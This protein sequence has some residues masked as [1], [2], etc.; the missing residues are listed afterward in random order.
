MSQRQWAQLR[1]HFST[2][3]RPGYPPEVGAIALLGVSRSL[4]RT[5]YL[6]AELLLPGAGDVRVATHG[7]L[8]LDSRYL[9]RAHLAMRQRKLAGL[10]VFHTHPLADE[11]VGFSA[12]DDDQEPFLVEN[13]KEMAP[14]T[15]FLS[16]VAGRR[17]QCGR[18]WHGPERWTPL[19][20]LKVIGDCLDN[21]S[22]AGDPAPA[23]PPPEAVFDRGLA[24]TGAGALARL[25]DMDVVVVG[26]SGTGSLMCEL[27]ARGGCRRIRVI[28]DQAVEDVNLNRILHAG[29]R[30]VRT[31]TRKVDLIRDSLRAYELDCEVEAIDGN[32]LDATFLSQIKTADVIVGCVDAAFPRSLLCDLA[33]QYLIPYIDVG[34][35]I[36]GDPKGLVALMARTSYV[37]PGR[38]CLSCTGIVEPR[39]L[40]FESLTYEERQRV[41]RLGYSDDLLITQPAVM[42]LNMRAAS[43]G[44]MLLRHLLQPFLLEPVPVT[45]S[46]NVLTYT[47]VA[48]GAPRTPNARCLTCRENP[49]L[50]CGDCG[51][52]IG[53][54]P[55]AVAAIT[56]RSLSPIGVQTN[57]IAPKRSTMAGWWRS[58]FRRRAR[59][60]NR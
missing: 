50:G 14:E 56:G 48:V 36:G 41:R 3:F 30:H 25:A 39:R 23:P 27:L 32:I 47:T 6:V 19:T 29:R 26:A 10:A 38:H 12:Y 55:A 44:M 28:D 24:L 1:R 49:H 46:E 52:A 16:I 37:A 9:R 54:D 58:L 35:E 18:V 13:L 45:I 31:G 40:Q 43:M 22:L 11:T 7:E 51:P 34:S 5:D 17:S 57:D 20:T 21:L 53:L 42:D 60:K 8:V 59:S 2:S 4:H 15:E 33:Y